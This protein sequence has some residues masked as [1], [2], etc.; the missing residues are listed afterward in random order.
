MIKPVNFETPCHISMETI[1]LFVCLLFCSSLIHLYAADVE[2]SKFDAVSTNI[3]MNITVTLAPSLVEE[4]SLNLRA[5]E[6]TG[7]V[8]FL[9]GGHTTTNIL[10]TSTL[11]IIGDQLSSI[12][13]NMVLEAKVGETVVASNIFTVIDADMIPESKVND[14]AVAK[15]G[16]IKTQGKMI[17]KSEATE[18]AISAIRGKIKIQEGAPITVEFKG[19]DCIVTYGWIPP[20]GIKGPILGPD[21]SA[22]V[23]LDAYTGSVKKILGAP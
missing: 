6:G 7:G 2:I 18:I 19:R 12:R 22:K 10:Q 21:Y 5:I 20:K 11:Q 4:V 17:T 16:K 13:N 8:V 3:S 14:T 15:K 1:V 9:P 23:I